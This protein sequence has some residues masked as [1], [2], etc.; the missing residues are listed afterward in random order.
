MNPTECSICYEIMTEK[1]VCETEC[2]H[3][4]H[5]ACIMKSAA[6]TGF[7][8]PYCRGVMAED[9]EDSDTESDES[10]NESDESEFESDD[11]S[12]AETVF[13]ATTLTSFRRMFDAQTDE[14]IE[15]ETLHAARNLFNEFEAAASA[16]YIVPDILPT[17]DEVFQ[18][19]KNIITYEELAKN[20][21][22]YERKE[23]DTGYSEE[24]EDRFGNMH[25]KLD[26]FFL[27][28]AATRR[29]QHPI[30]E[31]EAEFRR[32]C[33]DLAKPEPYQPVPWYN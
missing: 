23:Y 10:D 17:I 31:E 22:Y 20:F 29:V 16:E 9:P 32:I 18:G 7:C 15:A 1:A 2:G 28:Y 8:C 6:Y 30:D 5:T 11:V 25:D 4:F 3:K 13:A 12:E 14:D 21:I 26:R 19:M 33:A 27:N 24:D